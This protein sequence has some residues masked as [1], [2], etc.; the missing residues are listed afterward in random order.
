MFLATI[1]V[2]RQASPG[3][4]FSPPLLYL[5]IR[6]R[7]DAHSSGV[8]LLTNLGNQRAAVSREHREWSGADLTMI[9]RD[10]ACMASF[11][12]KRRG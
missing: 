8:G 6:S 11:D 12:E 4:R 3:L 9:V 5:P 2:P 10:L 1:A 7:F